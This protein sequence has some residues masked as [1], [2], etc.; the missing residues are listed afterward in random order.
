MVQVCVG[1]SKLEQLCSKE[2]TEQDQ[3]IV[4]EAVRGEYTAD[5]CMDGKTE[6]E[7]KTGNRN[8]STDTIYSSRHVLVTI[9]F[10]SLFLL[11]VLKVFVNQSFLSP[12]ASLSKKKKK[13]S[14][15]KMSRFLS[16]Y[17]TSFSNDSTIYTTVATELNIY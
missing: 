13:K 3:K 5:Y 9:Y 15:C 6:K 12:D 7:K 11:K 2:S 4:L 16:I 10:G 8:Y 1:N 17:T 14:F